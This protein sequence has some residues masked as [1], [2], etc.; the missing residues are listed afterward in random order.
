MSN[1]V[2]KLEEMLMQ[3]RELF[4]EEALKESFP[5]LVSFV[6]ETEQAM[7]THAAANPSD[8]FA[9]DEM[10]VETL[11]MRQTANADIHIIFIC[12][13]ALLFCVL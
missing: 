8:R 4:A 11:V 9:L 5:K 2:Q 7:A 3:Q 12:R 13:G 6:T 10:L 1:E